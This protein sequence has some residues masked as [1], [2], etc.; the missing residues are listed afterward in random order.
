MTF[1]PNVL[2]LLCTF[3]ANIKHH[4]WFTRV[5]SFP[6]RLIRSAI[7]ITVIRACFY[8]TGR[9]ERRETLPRRDCLC[10]V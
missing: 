2:Q 4:P 1:D 3:G 10:G 9:R 6:E 8:Y 7:K 5:L